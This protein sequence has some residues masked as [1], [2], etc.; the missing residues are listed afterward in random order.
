MI[1]SIEDIVREL[2]H[3]QAMH[4]TA[5]DRVRDLKATSER[6]HSEALEA[7]A[8]LV[9]AYPELDK[10]ECRVRDLRSALIAA[11]GEPS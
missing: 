10:W 7:D 3:A 9:D 1:H 5:G 4:E 2:R 6:A 8:E 11:E